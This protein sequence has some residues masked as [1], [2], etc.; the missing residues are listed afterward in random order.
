MNFLPE[1]H[2]KLQM[3]KA[4]LNIAKLSEGEHRFRIVMRPIA[5]WI[6][7]LNNKP[8]R[9]KP[10]QK[11]E[12]SFDEE[13]PM[14]RFWVCYVW[15]YTKEGLYIMEL[16]QMSILKGLT[17]LAQDAEWGDF[18]TYDIK[19]KKEG[20]GKNSKYLVSPVPHKPISDRIKMA[21]ENRPVCLEA[22][23]YGKDPW[24]D[25][26]EGPNKITATLDDPM[27]QLRNF[28]SE[29]GLNVQLLAN[30]IDHLSVKKKQPIED[31]VDS[32]LT[33][34]ILPLFKRSYK[35]WLKSQESNEGEAL[36]V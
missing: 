7:W 26:I 21:M 14:K 27:D 30:Y 1:G 35:T 8:Y 24:T 13:K 15:D 22:L 28:I 29:D 4:Y 19:I 10:D 3:D 33:K 6:D 16:T 12:K 5:G 25:F 9:Y 23:Y 36:T 34:E 31:I 32:A 20:N 11:P 18:T 2:D 17:S